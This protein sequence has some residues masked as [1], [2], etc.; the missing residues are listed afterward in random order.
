MAATPGGEGCL[1]FGSPVQAHLEQLGQVLAEVGPLDLVAENLRHDAYD[2]RRR[3]QT[4]DASSVNCVVARRW[5]QP[6]F[7]LFLQVEFRCPLKHQDSSIPA[8][9]ISA[10]TSST[11]EVVSRESLW[12]RSSSLAR[13]LTARTTFGPTIS[14][15]A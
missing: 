15:M 5:G 7:F 14:N 12:F 4:G 11:T 1:E 10:S 9:F 3:T 2:G 13:S 6:D 8:S